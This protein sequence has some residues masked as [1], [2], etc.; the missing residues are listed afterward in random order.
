[1]KLNDQKLT[2]LIR[3]ISGII[4]CIFSIDVIFFNHRYISQTFIGNGL[5]VGTA[6]I[7]VQ[8]K[9]DYTKKSFKERLLIIASIL[10]IAFILLYFWYN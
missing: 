7:L 3:C 6:A 4:L 8:Y 2:T 1:M 10:V 9:V 5:V